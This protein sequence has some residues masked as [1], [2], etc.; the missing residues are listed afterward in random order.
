MAQVFDP[1][2]Q[3]AGAG[4]SLEFEASLVYIGS[5]R[6]ATIILRGPVSKSK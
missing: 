1:N 3:E 5:S 4:G 2:T 6:I